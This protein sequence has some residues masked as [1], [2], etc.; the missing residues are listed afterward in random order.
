VKEKEK[1]TLLYSILL[2]ST[3]LVSPPRLFFS[4]NSKERIRLYKYI[5][6][7]VYE[8]M[9]TVV[10]VSHVIRIHTFS[11]PILYIPCTLM[12]CFTLLMNRRRLYTFPRQEF[13]L[14]VTA[15]M[16]SA[17]CLPP[18]H[19]STNKNIF[20]FHASIFHKGLFDV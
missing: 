8:A 12:H 18:C 16:R 4:C 15:A 6:H 5:S 9:D 3:V 14:Y 1:E 2:C 17:F 10:Q 13:I 19:F 7:V 11:E 20:F